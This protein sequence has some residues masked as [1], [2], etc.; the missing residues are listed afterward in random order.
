M[1]KMKYNIVE[2]E[3]KAD[4]RLQATIRRGDIFMADLPK[5]IGCEQG[6][7]RPVVVIQNNIGNFRSS[8]VIIASVTGARKKPMPTHV[9]LGKAQGLSRPSLLLLESIYTID[10]TRLGQYIGHLQADKIL[11]MD[12]AAAISIGLLPTN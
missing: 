11:Q 6:G 7:R 8:L 12:R 10:K 2:M 9:P 4:M 1:Q 5:G 3:M